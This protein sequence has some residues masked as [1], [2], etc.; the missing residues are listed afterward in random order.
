MNDSHGQVLVVEQNV[1]VG[2]AVASLLESQGIVAVV[3]QS[4]EEAVAA[5]RTTHFDL[6]LIDPTLPGLGGNELL[7]ALKEADPETLIVITSGFSTVNDAA[8]AMRAGA[9]DY[10]PK[11]VRS[12]ELVLVVKRAFERIGESARR[13]EED[14]KGFAGIVGRSEPMKSIFET[15]R[16]VRDSRATVLIEGESGTGKELVARAIHEQSKRR[17]FPFVSIHCSAIPTDLL[18]SELFGHEKGAFTGAVRMQKGKFELA[19]RGTLLLDEIATL[20]QRAQVDLL[21][22]MQER[23]FTRI[24]GSETIRT[25]ARVIATTN[26]PLRGLVAAG[27]F[28]EDLYY[29]FNVVR[30][31]MAPLRK[32]VEDIALLAYAFIEKHASDGDRAVRGISEA[33]LDI[34]R[35]VPWPGNIRELENAIERAIVMGSGAEILP[36]HLPPE[37]LEDDRLPSHLE[38][39]HPLPDGDLRMAD[40][41]AALE[42]RLILRALQNSNQHRVGAA[43]EL[44]ITERTLRYKMKNYGIDVPR[45]GAAGGPRA[46][47]TE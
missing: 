18:E 37:I 36:H 40:R 17:A 44:G 46:R 26:K 13:E 12:E 38:D 33:A 4:G 6:A 22:V 14:E 31:E 42:E 23:K 32:R 5:M 47:K 2:Q 3:L 24:G 9:F 16:K 43:Q 1:G 29:R 35:R 21:R 25:E 41:V 20:D 27:R 34:L 39:S 8:E 15:I 30:I 19:N 11:P 10:L 7:R 45:S 28:R